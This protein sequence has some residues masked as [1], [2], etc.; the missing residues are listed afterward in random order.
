MAW[1]RW[2]QPVVAVCEVVPV[3]AMVPVCPSIVHIPA[4]CS[5]PLFNTAVVWIDWLGLMQS[6]HC[7]APSCYRLLQEKN[8]HLV[9]INSPLC[10]PCIS[11]YC[12]GCPPLAVGSRHG[13]L[14]GA[15][16]CHAQH[17]R[18]ILYIYCEYG[19]CEFDKFRVDASI[20]QA[21]WYTGR[22]LLQ[23]Y[24][25]PLNTYTCMYMN[26]MDDVRVKI[27][28]KML[29]CRKLLILYQY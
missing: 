19:R 11:E 13:W 5:G 15:C 4:L 2:E 12:Y 9:S 18:G 25:Y 1:H 16:T 3:V 14:T 6:I 17:S 28:S 22:S 29:S 24:F 21:A 10:N 27:N 26:P 7:F 20:S 23:V 8:T